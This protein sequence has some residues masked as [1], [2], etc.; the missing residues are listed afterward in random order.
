[1]LARGVMK[2]AF[3]VLVVSVCSGAFT[4]ATAFQPL[5]TCPG[6]QQTVN[7]AVTS[8]VVPDLVAPDGFITATVIVQ[9]AG[10]DAAVDAEMLEQPPE[11]TTYESITWTATDDNWVCTVPAVGTHGKISCTNKCFMPGSSVTFTIESRAE[12]CVGSIPLTSTATVSSASTESDESD[13]TA[14]ATNSVIDPGTCDDGDICTDT[15]RCAP[16]IAYSESF[17]L[18]EA[19]NLPP[20]WTTIVLSGPS[21]ARAWTTTTLHVDTPPNAAFVPNASDVRDFALD[22]PSIFVLSPT[23]QVQFRNR[24]DLERNNDGGVLEIKIEGFPFF[25]DI[26]DAGGSF[27]SGGYDGVIETNFGNPIAGRA[28]WTGTRP[29]FVLTTVNLPATAAGKTIVLRWR[30]ATDSALGSTGQWIDSIVVTGKS[31]CQPGP[32]ATCDDDDACTIDSC[33]GATGCGHLPVPCDDGE[34][35]TADTCDAVLGCLHANTTAPCNDLNACTQTDL[36]TGGQCVGS[37][38]LS[39]QDTD[40]CTAD[41]CDRALGCIAPTAN[42]DTTGF[43]AGRVDGRDLAVLAQSWFSCP[44]TL[45]YNP[46][47][48]LDRAQP[49]IEDADFHLF[50]NAFA[51]DCAP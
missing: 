11:G 49:C 42:F 22:S 17:D 32:L 50:M 34:P 9:N 44:N 18:I 10:P 38:A 25:E 21:G 24:Y 28:A 40:V 1:M 6:D 35:C 41:V 19:P 46:A 5:N 33:D 45:R 3:V 12:I 48:N 47:A 7:L 20:G 26:L 31:A 51:R 16:S 39:C 13:N 14:V 23:A 30:V 43:S 2:P 29:Q 36:C 4:S 37:N 8:S 27:V 15:D